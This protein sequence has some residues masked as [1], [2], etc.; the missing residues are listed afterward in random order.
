MFFDDW[1]WP[2]LLWL[3]IW[4]VVSLGDALMDAWGKRHT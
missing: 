3:A 4:V 1:G 2:F